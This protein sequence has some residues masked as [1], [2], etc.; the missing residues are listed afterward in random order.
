MLQR[1]LTGITAI[2]VLITLVMAEVFFAERRWDDHL[3]L[4]KL[5]LH[6]SII[7]ILFTA[8][9]LVGVAE[10]T[11][12]LRKANLHPQSKWAALS[13]VVLMLSPWLCAAGV[14][15]D[16]VIDVEALHWQLLWFVI[17]IVGSVAIQLRKPSTT[18]A[19]TDLASTWMIIIFLGL[20]PSFAIQI[21]ADANAAN[22]AQN[23][24][25]LFFIIMVISASDIGAFFIG[26]AIGKH[27]L[28]PAVSPAKSV[29]GMFGGILGSIAVAALFKVLANNV[30]IPVLDGIE[31]T[32]SDQFAQLFH[33][34]S[35]IAGGMNWGQIAIF[36]A[37]LSICTQLGDLFESM[38]KRCP[39]VKDSSAVIPGMGGVLD[40]ID[41]MLF[42]I[43]AAWY[44]LT[45]AWPLV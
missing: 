42:A 13:C 44:L 15:G 27:K 32:R 11:F 18:T 8:V 24:W 9:I 23:P 35:A 45:R 12:I 33:D 2:A 20:L 38:C 25:T 43:P 34:V 7:P 22:I 30:Q 5:F 16:G 4:E 3:F 29:E 17:A 31:P 26:S 41:G 14:I 40:L 6:G 36:G 28:A 21:R 10:M 1:I 19:I 39:Q 37:V